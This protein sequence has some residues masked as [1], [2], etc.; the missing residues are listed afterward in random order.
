MLTVAMLGD[1]QAISPRHSWR[2]RDLPEAEVGH[3]YRLDGYLP[4][5]FVSPA[6]QDLLQSMASGDP[7]QPGS[8]G[9]AQEES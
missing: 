9:R 5:F 2:N 8:W 7:P 4:L 1:S 6:T 3:F